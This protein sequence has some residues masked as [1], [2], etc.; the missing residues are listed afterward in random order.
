MIMN[1]P[2]TFVAT[3]I[4]VE[5]GLIVM[6]K[7]QE[8]IEMIL[9]LEIDMIIINKIQDIIQITKVIEVENLNQDAQDHAPNRLTV[10]NTTKKKIVETNVVIDKA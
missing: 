3:V 10:E 5:I 2:E 9:M 7:A 8:L 1:S 4:E 6:K